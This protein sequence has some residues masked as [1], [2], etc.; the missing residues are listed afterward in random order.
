MKFNI[1]NYSTYN[2]I[3]DF[4]DDKPLIGAQCI[5]PISIQ[6]SLITTFVCVYQSNQTNKSNSNTSESEIIYCFKILNTCLYPKYTHSNPSIESNNIIVSDEFYNKY[7]SNDN[8][9]LTLNI[10]YDIPIVKTIKLKRI[11]GDFPSDDSIE[12]LLTSYFESSS[13]VNLGQTFTLDLINNQIIEFEVDNIT[14]IE[15][16]EK[17]IID[18]IVEIDYQLKLNNYLAD[19]LGFDQPTGMNECNIKV[20]NYKWHYH[21]NG[22]KKSYVGCLINAEVEIDF[23]ISE[24]VKSIEPVESDKFVESDKSILTKLHKPIKS[25]HPFDTMGN[26]LNDIS[27]DKSES[28]NIKPSTKEEMRLK[29]LNFFDKLQK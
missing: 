3:I 24:P 25:S 28:L 5:Y 6:S 12:Y 18:R 7:F 14:Y 4:I 8:S 26:K 9:D 23:V 22:H 19:E 10:L 13:V 20:Y 2:A 29:R 15:E 1:L 17:K 27:L 16:F 21:T 11:N